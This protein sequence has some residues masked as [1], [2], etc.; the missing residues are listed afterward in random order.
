MRTL[1]KRTQYSLRALY[2]LA[3]NYQKGPR[4]IAE[5]AD[6]EAIPKKFLEQILLTL[7]SRGLVESKKGRGGGYALSRP[8][9]EITLGSVIRLIEGPL[10]P[11]PC[12]SE[13]AF[14]K[15]QECTDVA[16]CGT[17]LV[18]RDVRNAIAG[19]LDQATLASV[20]DRVALAQEKLSESQ[21]PAEPQE[22][23]YYI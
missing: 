12:A 11:I 6:E 18:M 16:T 9:N 10:A 23:M 1:S 20:C 17:R 4:L 19:V 2:A 21:E 15:C 22:L 7:K 13:T 14:R 5:L 8:P 3:R